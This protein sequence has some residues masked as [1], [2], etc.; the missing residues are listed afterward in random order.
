M[1]DPQFEALRWVHREEGQHPNQRSLE[2][3]NP[4]DLVEGTKAQSV[5]LDIT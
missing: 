2:H 3:N 5:V 1:L 4:S